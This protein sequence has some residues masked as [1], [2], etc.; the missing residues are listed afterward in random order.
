MVSLLLLAVGCDAG[1]TLLERPVRVAASPDRVTTDDGVA[2]TLTQASYTLA[3]LRFERPADTT[4][5]L[6][7][8]SLFVSTA[9][10]HPG[11]DFAGGVGG[12]LSGS[13][14]VDL[15]AGPT[16]L[17]SALIYDGPYETARLTLPGAVQLAGTADGVAFALE[18]V[19]DQD[20]TGIPF[21]VTVVPESSGPVIELAVDIGHALS[22]V[23]WTTPDAD[24]DGVLTTADGVLANTVMFGVVATPSFSLTIDDMEE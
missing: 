9:H 17:G 1:H 22:F 2:I 6:H 5:A 12:E 3:D 15:L 7:W 14:A 20:V 4:V 23:D 24:A 10:A 8:T 11:H 18:L 16:E 19:P 21:E 13:W